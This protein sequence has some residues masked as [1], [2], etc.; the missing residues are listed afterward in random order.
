MHISIHSRNIEITDGIEN[1]INK[2]FE[3]LN[4]IIHET[5]EIKVVISAIPR[6]NGAQK[7]EATLI[8]DGTMIRSECESDDLYSSIN[9]AADTLE[10]RVK[11]Y[12]GKRSA[13]DNDSIRRP[14]EDDVSELDSEIGRIKQ[15]SLVRKSREE[16][17]EQMELLGHPFHLF[18]DEISGTPSVLY[19]RTHGGYGILISD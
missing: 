10:R 4:R 6:K 18:I 5:A 1:R 17:I 7:V 9:D 16:A 15:V 11:A 14:E 13:R 19:K 12:K 8:L 2:A 3:K